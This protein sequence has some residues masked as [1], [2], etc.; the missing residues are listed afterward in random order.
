MT[1]SRINQAIKHLGL[2]IVHTRGSGCSYFLDAHGNQVGE[3]IMVCCLNQQ[4]LD[5]WVETAKY[6]R[7]QVI[8]STSG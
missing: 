3:S 2:K 1:T 5:Q 8:S 4:T 7:K 6:T